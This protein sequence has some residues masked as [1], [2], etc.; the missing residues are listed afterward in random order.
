MKRF[1]AI[2]I[3]LVLAL[4]LAGCGKQAEGFF[5]W[6]C[7]D[8]ASFVKNSE[9]GDCCYACIIN[10]EYEKC[11]ECGVYYENDGFDC[12]EVYC[13]GCFNDYSKK[14]DVYFCEDCG[15]EVSA[16]KETDYGYICY[17]CI[18]NK[19]YEKCL[20]CGAYYKN[21][22][23]DCNGVYCQ[24]CFAD[25][26][27]ICFLCWQSLG[28]MVS[29]EIDGEQYFICPDCAT[30]YFAKIDP[31]RPVDSCIE[32]GHLYPLGDYYYEHF[33]FYGAS[34]CQECLTRCGYE[35]CDRC[36]RY[37]DEGLIDGICGFC[38]EKESY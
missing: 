23:F 27:K 2:A 1:A 36:E 21:D 30:E 9:N 24:N 29:L 34:I 12:N 7:G 37:T 15:E 6:S 5:C 20:E 28:E 19:E 4:S 25:N 11:L 3:C 18:I 31:L 17:A 38:I 8:E 32:C 22:G 14:E 16:V 10:N 13:H 26:G 35:K 33:L